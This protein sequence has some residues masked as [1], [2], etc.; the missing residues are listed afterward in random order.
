MDQIR[1]ISNK[2]NFNCNI[3]DYYSYFTA[4]II[5]FLGDSIYSHPLSNCDDGYIDILSMSK[6]TKGSKFR[7]MKLLINQDTG[8]YFNKTTNTNTFS[9]FKSSSNLKDLRCNQGISYI[10]TKGFLIKPT[11]PKG[12]T[13]NYSIDGERYPLNNALV[14]IVPSS[15][16]IFGYIK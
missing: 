6:K 10:K 4:N 1:D 8:D 12:L 15:L 11:N 13:Q 2:Y 16:K 9:E 5:P 3:N 14:K 7:L